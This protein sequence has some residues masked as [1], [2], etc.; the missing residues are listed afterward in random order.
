MW[1]CRRCGGSHHFSVCRT[2]PS[3]LPP[4][5]NF[6]VPGGNP[7][8]E[9]PRA[10]QGV[11]ASK[12]GGEKRKH[13]WQVCKPECSGC[14]FCNGGLA[15]CTVCRGAEGSLPSECP[16]T[17]MTREQEEDVY[18]GKLDFCNGAWVEAPPGATFTAYN[19]RL[20]RP[21]EG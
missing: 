16:G 5:Q 3:D 15:L 21:E 9:M 6:G 11:Q 20:G 17:E 1:L 7:A 13:V 19:V 14:K 2:Y 4:A 12:E 10:M 8:A 18:T